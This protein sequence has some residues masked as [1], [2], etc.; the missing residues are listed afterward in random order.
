MIRWIVTCLVLLVPLHLGLAAGS[1]F[2]FNANA[3]FG[4]QSSDDYTW[5]ITS[6]IGKKTWPVSLALGCGRTEAWYPYNFYD[7]GSSVKRNVAEYNL[8]VRKLWK[9][10]SSYRFYLEE[11]IAGLW[12]SEKRYS[13]TRH[14]TSLGLWIGSGFFFEFFSFLNV[15]LELR[16]SVAYKYD[17]V[18]GGLVFGLHYGD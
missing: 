1:P 18:R 3:F 9:P 10:T 5:G 7:M 2:H 12:F 17:N 6:D 15:G 11:G 4:P 14:T 16:Y 8:G 13:Y